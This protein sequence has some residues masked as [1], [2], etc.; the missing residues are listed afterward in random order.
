MLLDL[1]LLINGLLYIVGGKI[2][3]VCI[4]A[5]H[6]KNMRLRM[7][8]LSCGTYTAFHFYHSVLECARVTAFDVKASS[9]Q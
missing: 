4:V 7:G 6:W 9:K 8:Y 1:T 3:V 5:I 2:T